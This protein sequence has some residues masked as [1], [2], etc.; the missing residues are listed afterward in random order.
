MLAALDGGALLDADALLFL[1]RCAQSTADDNL[2]ARVGEALAAALPEA[3]R[4]ST[5]PACAAWV[6]LLVETRQLSDDDRL[7]R[8]IARLVPALQAHWSAVAI[9]DAAAAIEATLHAVTLPPFRS[10]AAAAIDH[11]ERLIATCY[12]PGSR[13]GG[14]PDQVRT[15]SALLTAYGLSGRLPYPMLAEEL[16]QSARTALPSDFTSTCIAARVLCRLAALHADSAY[17]AA[18]ILAPH[19]AYRDDAVRLLETIADDAHARGAAGAIYG[20]ALLELES[21]P[22]LP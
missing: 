7:D 18:A 9:G 21:A 17:R 4:A 11:L 12:R 10:I 2:V 3:E 8:A 15:A 14:P 20:V 5:V 6:A 1:L 13:M 19:A 22:L 16:M